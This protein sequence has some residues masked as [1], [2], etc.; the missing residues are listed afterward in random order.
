VERLRGAIDLS[1]PDPKV[2]TLRTLLADGRPTLVFCNAVATVPYLRDRLIDL[3]P[4]WVTGGRAGWRHVT[5]PRAQVLSWFRPGTPEVTPRVLLAS[6]VAAEGLDLQ[7]AQRVVHYDLP[8][9]AMRLAQREGR[10]RRLGG[11]HP[12][13]DV[14]RFDP[15]AWIERRL[16]IGAA[17]RRKHLLGRRAGFEGAD[18]PWRWRHDLASAWDGRPVA[19]GIA[20]VRGTVDRLLIGVQVGEAAVRLA[21]ID[22]GGRWTEAPRTVRAVL[23]RI[24][25]SAIATDVDWDQWRVRSAPFV[26][27][28]LR[29][30]TGGLWRAA[31]NRSVVREFI[32]RLQG[33]VRRATRAR[34]L[35]AL[36]RLE[37]LLAF[38]ARGH[39]A[40]EEAL[41]EEW[42][43]LDD[44]ALMRNGNGLPELREAVEMPSLRIVG[45][46]A[47][48]AYCP[49]VTSARPRT[50]PIATDLSRA[51][52]A[53]SKTIRPV[54]PS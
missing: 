14:V 32:A 54:T 48:V 11:S 23:D 20:A 29:D 38:A 6:D 34:D 2:E 26:R 39:T 53:E 27:T 5:V 3:V 41:I 37:P 13:I 28:V 42:A 24:E 4:A 30:A 36:E 8:W 7:R 47:E 50:T 31:P 33:L 44:I 46:I 40:G 1:L 12:E 16:R 19:R 15:P 49:A 22:A 9:T 21:V 10:S 45:A 52:P 25:T 18:S 43:R 17:L 51:S 35:A